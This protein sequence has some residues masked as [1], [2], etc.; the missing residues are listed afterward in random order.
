MPVTDVNPMWDQTDRET[1]LG[2]GQFTTKRKKAWQVLHTADTDDSEIER[3]P[4]VTLGDTYGALTHVKANRR[5]MQRFSPI[6]STVFVE[7]EGIIGE[8][9]TSP[10]DSRPKID[11]LDAATTEQIDEDFNGKPIMTIAGERFENVTEEFVDRMI[12]IQRNF[13]TFNTAAVDPYLRS[14]NQDLFLG[15][16]PGQARMKSINASTVYVGDTTDVYYSVTARVHCRVIT[17]ASSPAKTWYKRLRHEGYYC[18]VPNPFDGGALIKGQCRVKGKPVTRPA[19]L[20]TDGQMLP[21]DTTT[22]VWLEFQTL[23]PLPYAALG[24]LR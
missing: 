24:L 7:Y 4:G 13:L 15:Y 9:E 5:Y 14:V 10:F 12:V 23:Q 22:A 1:T 11:F 20:D 2:D 6:A 3:S 18:L 8:R 19:L 16:L 21:D 17:R